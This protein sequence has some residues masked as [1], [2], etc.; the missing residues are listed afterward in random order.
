[1]ASNDGGLQILVLNGEEDVIGTLNPDLVDVDEINNDIK[2]IEITHP[3][4]DD[5]GHDYD[6]LLVQGNKIWKN[7]TEDGPSC[8]YV[9][10]DDKDNDG[11]FIT[12]T[13]E[14]VLVELNNAGMME[15]STAITQAINGA[16]LTNWFGDYFT[17]GT[18]EA[19][20]K[21]SSIIWQG[22]MARMALLRFIEEET[23]NIF[24]TRYEYDLETKVIHRY[25]DLL[26]N[27]GIIHTTPL[28]VGEN[29]E[30]ITENINEG[31]TY[32]AVAPQLSQQEST[33]SV[34]MPK[35]ADVMAQY[36]AL[37]VNVGQSI[38]MFY[39]RDSQGN[40]ISTTPWNAPFKKD[41]GSWEVYLAPE[42]ITASYTKIHRKEGNS[43]HG[44]KV[45]PLETSET[46]KYMIYNACALKLLDK[47]DPLLETETKI[48][49]L[50][51]L[52]GSEEH[53]NVGDRVY[54]RT[55]NGGIVETRIEET[56]KNPRNPGQNDIKVGNS[57]T[58]SMGNR[59][60][61]NRPAGIDSYTLSQIF[62]E[63]SDVSE[64]IPGVADVRINLLCPGIAN[65]Q[66]NSNVPG[67]VSNKLSESII[68]NGS[69][70]TTAVN[71]SNLNGGTQKVYTLQGRY[72]I[73][74]CTAIPHLYV[75]INGDTGNNYDNE[76]LKVIDGTVTGFS[77]D[78]EPYARLE[79]GLVSANPVIFWFNITVLNGVGGYHAVNAHIT[80][81]DTTTLSTKL[82]T[83]S[84]I[85]KVSEDINS[86]RIGVSGGVT[87]CNYNFK[88]TTPS[89]P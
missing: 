78:N 62:G 86:I 2:Q 77:A 7:R 50:P 28:E 45:Y 82:F 65:T 31:D 70:T 6:S 60:N 34:D 35:I 9:L 36:K 22:T 74:A 42:Q 23:G 41:A 47:K 21:K 59:G 17:I 69:G 20:L 3:V 80:V 83:V 27:I 10:N 73:V 75:Q 84:S 16:N 87:G 76:V 5:T 72:Q 89:I 33:G 4:R 81:R 71:I 64:S 56:K 55:R 11:I 68:F 79:H 88:V 54:I 61:I 51:G 30:K 39:E 48:L 29:V 58:R 19:C 85:R 14:E 67:I 63:I 18:V 52:P 1:M 32:N 13:A 46:D 43:T 15:K 12:I 44:R 8:L 24:V 26:Q 37:A 38:P 57:I 49:D 53:Y 25:L 40:I 66:I